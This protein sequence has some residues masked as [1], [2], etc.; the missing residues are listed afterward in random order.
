MEK[1]VRTKKLEKK[2]VPLTRNRLSGKKKKDEKS[3][4]TKRERKITILCH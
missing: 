2:A 1:N 3:T 4:T